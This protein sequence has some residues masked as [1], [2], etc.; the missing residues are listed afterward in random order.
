[1]IYIYMLCNLL[2]SYT[3]VMYIVLKIFFV[4]FSFFCRVYQLPSFFSR[5]GFCRDAFCRNA[6][7]QTVTCRIAFCRI[8]YCRNDYVE[9]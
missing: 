8:A 3:L 9:L 5:N 7:C 6:F 4:E 2:F 1:M